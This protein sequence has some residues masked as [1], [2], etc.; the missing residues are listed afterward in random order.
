[1][2][3]S[4]SSNAPTYVTQYCS[5]LAECCASSGVVPSP[6]PCESTLTGESY[7]TTAG[8]ACLA[9]MQGEQDAGTLCKTFGGDIPACAQAFTAT[10]STPPGKTCFQDSD[11]EPGAGG[12]AICYSA[13][14]ADEEAGVT[15]T[16]TCIQLSQGPVGATPCIGDQNEDPSSYEWT[17]SGSLP[18]TAYVCN[19]STCGQLDQKCLALAA[20][21]QPCIQY[22]D[23]TPADYCAFNSSSDLVCTPRLADGDNCLETPT[24]CPIGSTCNAASTCVPLVAVGASCVVGADCET[25]NCVNGKCSSANAGLVCLLYAQ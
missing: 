6:Q 25:G 17:G 18:K 14:L 8:P 1:L 15:S 4:G 3:C 13:T 5:L 20:D 21:G 22:S 2:A 7:D 10:G 24:A 16:G 23:C 19:G 9:A 12:S 11:C